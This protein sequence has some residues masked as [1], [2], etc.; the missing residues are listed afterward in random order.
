MTWSR[1]STSTSANGSTGLPSSV[2]SRP[3]VD[4]AGRVADLVHRASSACLIRDRD[5]DAEPRVLD[6][7]CRG[8]LTAE[9]RADRARARIS[10]RLSAAS[11]TRPPVFTWSRYDLYSSTARCDVLGLGIDAIEPAIRLRRRERDLGHR[12]RLVRLVEV[13]RGRGEVL[14]RVRLRAGAEVA[15]GRV[16]VVGARAAGEQRSR[17]RALA[18]SAPPAPACSSPRSRELHCANTTSDSVPLA[19][20]SATTSSTPSPVTSPIWIAS[21]CS[22]CGAGRSAVNV[23][24]A[25]GHAIQRRA[26]VV[27]QRRS[28][29]AGAAPVVNAD[30]AR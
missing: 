16:L 2:A 30:R 24:A 29:R 19:P 5:V 27:A 18:S 9:A 23:P 20:S 13:R 28:G 14:R 6:D 3:L 7:R 21:T 15:L 12:H 11:P 26:G 22:R 17:S 8:A 25:L 1:A 4:L 10:P